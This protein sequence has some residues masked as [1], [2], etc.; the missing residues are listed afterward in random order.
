M[1]INYLQGTDGEDTINA[2]FKTFDGEGSGKVH[3]SVLKKALMTWGEKLTDEEVETAFRE[4]P[5]DRSGNIDITAFVKT[6]C[7]SA[8]EE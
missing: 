7:G 8:E 1:F 6:I 5:M 3:E 2:A 4:A